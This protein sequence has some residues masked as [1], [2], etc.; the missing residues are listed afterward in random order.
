MMLFTHSF[1]KNL[2]SI[3]KNHEG[4]NAIC[5]P[6]LIRALWLELW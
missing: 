5:I 2:L 3:Y 4:F 1:H 6:K